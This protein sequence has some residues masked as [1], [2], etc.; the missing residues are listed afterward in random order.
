MA[1]IDY[2]MPA[3]ICWANRPYWD[4]PGGALVEEY[5]DDF[6]LR[7]AV[8]FAALHLDIRR[9]KSVTVKCVGQEFNLQEI[10]GLFRSR[11]FPIDEPLRDNI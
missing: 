10:E 7:E 3:E 8:L 2:S 11:D 1:Q 9:C 5:W 6:T 4:D